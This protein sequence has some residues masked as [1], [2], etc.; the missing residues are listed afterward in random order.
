MFIKQATLTNKVKT[1]N[2]IRLA[3]YLR[4]ITAGRSHKEIAEEVFLHINLVIK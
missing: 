4:L 2:L 1:D 3:R